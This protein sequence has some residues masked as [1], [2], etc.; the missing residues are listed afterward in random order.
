MTT[1][2]DFDMMR[3]RGFV[4]DIET[5]AAMRGWTLPE[6]YTAAKAMHAA[7]FRVST[8][9]EP[10][11]APPEA[12]SKVESWV[13][14]EAERRIAARERQAVAAELVER[15]DRDA[16]RIALEEAPRLAGMLR[17]E[18]SEPLDTFRELLRSAPREVT[19]HTTTEEFAE[20]TALLRGSDEL[21]T[22]ANIRARFAQILDEGVSSKDQIWLV[23]DPTPDAYLSVVTAIA[24]DMA[25]AMPANVEQWERVVQVGASVAGFEGVRARVARHLEACHHGGYSSPDGGMRDKTYTEAFA[26]AGKPAAIGRN[27]DAGRW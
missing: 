4:R 12:P 8:S 11:A 23:M 1:N 17:A 18:F 15:T 20:H 21:T 14:A 19:S 25:G 6:G 27:D 22:L 24:T 3:A 16:M 2:S 7:A 5:I 26:L 9:V 10:P 13:R